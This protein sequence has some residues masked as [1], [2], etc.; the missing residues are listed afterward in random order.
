MFSNSILAHGQVTDA[1]GIQIACFFTCSHHPKAM[2]FCGEAMGVVMPPILFENAIPSSKAF[3][4]GS[5][6]GS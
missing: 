4:K 3:A 5:P 6:D 2:T 1:E